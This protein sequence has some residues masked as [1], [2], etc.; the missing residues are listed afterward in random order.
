MSLKAQ[1]LLMFGELI[2]IVV[3]IQTECVTMTLFTGATLG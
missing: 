2:L 3:T 1:G